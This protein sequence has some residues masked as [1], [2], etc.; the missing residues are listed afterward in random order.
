LEAQA[1]AKPVV[2]FDVGGVSEAVV[3]GETGLIMKPDS[4]ELADAIM[5]LLGNWSLRETMGIKGRKFV[6]ENFSWD[7]CAQ[8]MLKIYQEAFA[9][10]V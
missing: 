4:R 9:T 7:I 10:A 2:A 6:L 1:T 5:K 3:K 8:K